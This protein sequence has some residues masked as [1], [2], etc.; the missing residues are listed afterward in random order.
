MGNPSKVRSL[1]DSAYIVCYKENVDELECAL[2]K[3][4]F[5][6]YVSRQQALDSS[7][8]VSASIRCLQNHLTVWEKIAE[9]G[10]SAV[11][12][13]ADF[14][15][16]IGMRRL[17]PPFPLN[18]ESESFGYLYACG[19]EVYDICNETYF[20][21][22][23]SST[24]A[25]YVNSNAAKLLIKFSKEVLAGNVEQYSTWDTEIRYYLQCR[26]INSFVPFRNYGEH[27]GLPNPEHASKGLDG[28]HR[29]DRLAGKL[30]FLPGYARGSSFIFYQ[31]RV[32][33][34]FWGVGRLILGRS[35]T[36]NSILRQGSPI[37]FIVKLACR[38][39]F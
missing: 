5:S 4:G 1:A 19:I 35:T 10:V 21:G 34:W 13:E 27:G 8:H 39:F 22:H 30:H 20:R 9:C 12:V 11:I 14:V 24:V 25:Y 18:K 28:T 26:G 32:K 17:P 3:E 23:S 33:A 7:S 36:K 37:K 2:S 31:V 38:L 29:A 16:V 15:P 6:V